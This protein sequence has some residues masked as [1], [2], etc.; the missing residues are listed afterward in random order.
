V[1][2]ETGPDVLLLRP[3]IIN[4]YIEAPDVRSGFSRV[5][6]DSAGQMTLYMELYDS[7]TSTLLAR[8]V[9]PQAD[10]KAFAQVANRATNK[11]AADRIIKNWASLL[12]AHLSDVK[13]K[14]NN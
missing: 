9:D 12:S 3:A 5:I 2:D 7:A 6:V 13:Q 10:D 1:V 14:A 8:V 11:V 4:L